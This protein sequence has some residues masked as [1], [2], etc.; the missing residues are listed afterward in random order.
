[1]LLIQLI[2]ISILTLKTL[3]RLNLGRNHLSVG[4]M[5]YIADF[6]LNN[7]VNQNLSILY[8]NS[9]FVFLNTDSS[10]TQSWCK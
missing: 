2:L 8:L 10:D 6:L 1:M 4:G 3:Q 5:Q 7:Q 9:K